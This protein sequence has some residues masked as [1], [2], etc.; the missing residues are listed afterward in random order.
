MKKGQY[1]EP[2]MEILCFE[3]ED[4]V[5]TSDDNWLEPVDPFSDGLLIKT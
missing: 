2:L 4:V 5:S 3:K 1:D